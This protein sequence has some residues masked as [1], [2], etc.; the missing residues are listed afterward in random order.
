MPFWAATAFAVYLEMFSADSTEM[1][2]PAFVYAMYFIHA[3]PFCGS[4]VN[5][6]LYGRLLLLSRF[7]IRFLVVLIL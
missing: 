3:L 5:W 6:I 4:A 7:S 2:P 1:A